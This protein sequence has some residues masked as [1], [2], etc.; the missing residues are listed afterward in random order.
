MRSNHIDSRSCA[1]RHGR[2]STRRGSFIT[3]LSRVSAMPES[4][5]ERLAEVSDRFAFRASEY[6]LGLVDWSD[7]EDPIRALIVPRLEELED[8]GRLDASNE[9]CNTVMPGVQHKYP[10]TA[11]L[12]C[13]EA[14]GGYCRY[15]FRKRLFMRDNHEVSRDLGAGIAYVR[16]HLEI[17]DVLLTG[18]DPLLLSTRKLAEVLQALREIPHVRTVRIGTKMLAFDP[19]RLLDDTELQEL[20]AE[21]SGPGGRIYLM[22]H[23]D[24]PRELTEPA[25][26]AVDLAIRL[27]VICAN[28]CPVVA[29]VNDDPDVLRELFETT[30]NV[31]CPQY[32]VFQGRPTL[33]NAPFRVPIVRGFEL[34]SEAH[35][36]ASGLARR[37][38]FVMSHE[39]GKL[40]IVGVDEERIYMR[41]HRAKDA[42]DENRFVS[43]ARDDEAIWLDDLERLS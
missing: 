13:I 32:Y 20:L 27:G 5:R 3:D 4:E 36:G 33:G 14:C 26:E 38:R 30:S 2:R 37:A 28:Q 41:Y 10:D 22:V 42:A 29:G 39:S 8:F 31:G 7:P 21:Q 25:I 16:D 11:L 35:R 19:F 24:H 6:Y 40:E 18:G 43:F 9:A 12:L 15:C 1:P 17:T 23:F 34:I